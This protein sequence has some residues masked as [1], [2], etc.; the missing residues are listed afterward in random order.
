MPNARR[1]LA[2]A[3]TLLLPS[4]VLTALP[5]LASAQT[6]PSKTDPRNNLKP[7]KTD[8]GVAAKH[9]RLVSN[10]PKPAGFD[11]TRG[12]TF[13]NS[14]L[15]FGDKYVYQ[16][17]FAGF[18]IWDVSNPGKPT[19]VSSV[20][21][22]TS[23]GD[24]SIYGN[25]LFISAEGGGNRN[26]CAKGGVSDPKDHMAGVRIY[27]V[28]DPA[29][30][31][32][33]K[34]VQTCKGSH[35]H[36]LLPHSKDKNILYIYV[37]GSQGAR[38][39][40]EVA[41]CK[42]GDDPADESNSLFRL[43]VIKVDLRAPEKA[44]VVTGARIFTGLDAAPRAA[45]RP[46]RGRPAA[47]GAPTTPPPAPTGPRN[48]HDVT[49][50]PAAKLLAGAC[51]S[52]G[53]LVDVSN[54]EKPVRLDARA[55]TNFSLWHTAVFSND[56]KKVVFTDEWGGGTSPMCQAN[57]MME[58][59]GNTILTIDGK[60]KYTQHAYFKIPT[61]QAAEENCVSHNGGLIPVPGRDI[62]VQGWYQGGVSVM[63]FSDPSNPKEL[64]FFDR[65]AIDNPPGVDVPV[66]PAPAGGRGNRGTIG[67]SWGA[68][69][70]NGMIYSSEM[71][72]GFDI[73]ELEP[74]D[75]LSKNEI[76]AAKLVRFTQ[77]NPQSQPR[78]EWPA[79]FPVVRSYLDQ[80]VRG[81][82]L[83]AERTSEIARAIDAAEQKDGKGR[84]D[85]LNALARQVD[86]D[87]AGAKDADRVRAMS[88]AIKAL[89]KAT[90]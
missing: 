20:Q 50:Y 38:P 42:E 49:A 68:Y 24:P 8:A 35:T 61:A 14:D 22:I 64:A 84:R 48:C 62:M 66:T 34:N 33:V 58:M 17:N 37:S 9:M 18:T 10:T 25:L 51:G 26:D 76:E 41:G 11:S 82:G 2:L 31:R 90:K 73:L 56:G 69:Y 55:D 86:K 44:E 19:L 79:A 85:A 47:A 81:K 65:G 72:R 13:V 16:G 57:S 46:Q 54:P 78:I 32:L 67:G 6:Y 1:A 39:A 40:T 70:W 36:T 83:A 23:Q 63:E 5:T 60:K 59:G 77:Y 89:A 15:A 12:L 53:L 7:G 45:G 43:D 74:S 28:A 27:D 29:H 30:P 88:A 21:C 71:D 3:A 87:V 75:Q 4:L 80:L 52:Y